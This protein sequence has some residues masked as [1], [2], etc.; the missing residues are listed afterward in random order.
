MAES[1]ADN[2][3][4]GAPLSNVERINIPGADFLRG[5]AGMPMV[6]Q[7]ALLVAI[8]GSVAIGLVAVLWMQSPDFRP[9]SG[10]NSVQQAGE[11]DRGYYE[12]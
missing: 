5:A 6:R 4:P 3:L 1:I 8:A 9:L 7:L 2:T 12:R 10:I 11:V